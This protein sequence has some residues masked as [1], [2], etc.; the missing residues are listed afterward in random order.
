M[1]LER[2]K[3]RLDQLHALKSMVRVSFLASTTIG[4]VETLRRSQTRARKRELEL[5]FEAW[6]TVYF[7]FSIRLLRD[8][9]HPQ[10]HFS[11][12]IFLL[13]KLSSFI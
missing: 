8:E 1:V 6:F 5:V 4:H 13:S 2:K 7:S 3:R 9:T 10:K 11:Q 12:N